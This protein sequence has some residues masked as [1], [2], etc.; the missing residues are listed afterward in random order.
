VTQEVRT[1]RQ[2]RTLRLFPRRGF[3]AIF[4]SYAKRIYC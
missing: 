4:S 3:G 2:A 1:G